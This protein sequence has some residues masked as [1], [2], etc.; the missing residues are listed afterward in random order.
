[1]SIRSGPHAA[2]SSS[3]R[4]A[5]NS[6]D[7]RSGQG[8]LG[9]GIRTAGP[10]RESGPIVIQGVESRMLPRAC[11]AP[12]PLKSPDR[13]SGNSGRFDGLFIDRC[14]PGGRGS[15]TQLCAQ[16]RDRILIAAG[17]DFDPAVIKVCR[18]AGEAKQ[19]GL[20]AGP[21]AESDALNA[22]GYQEPA[23]CDHWTRLLI[24]RGR[25]QP[26]RRPPADGKRVEPRMLGGPA[27]N[28]SR[29]TDADLLDIEQ[30]ALKLV[31]FLRRIV[32]ARA[33]DTGADLL[34]LSVRS[35][36]GCR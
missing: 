35:R 18:P 3:A 24:V 34:F 33:V 23:A 21:C 29:R 1:M 7:V 22:S 15:C 6:K 31:H 27:A 26:V 13:E 8:S 30:T 16:Q 14:H 4:R 20:L 11:R 19:A 28:L 9:A 32:G 17:D 12:P 25:S 2:I 10:D 5:A 36:R